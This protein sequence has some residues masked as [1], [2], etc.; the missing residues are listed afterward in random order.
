MKS[1]FIDFESFFV[2][3]IWSFIESIK[4]DGQPILMEKKSIQISPV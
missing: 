1:I 3:R 2:D 4:I